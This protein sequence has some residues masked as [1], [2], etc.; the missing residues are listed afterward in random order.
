MR[1]EKNLKKLGAA[2]FLYAILIISDIS[3]FSFNWVGKKNMQ[4]LKPET[5]ENQ[6]LFDSNKWDK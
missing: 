2:Y 4:K 5:F 3:S 1:F 6:F